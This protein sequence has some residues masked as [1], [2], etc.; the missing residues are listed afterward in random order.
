MT[1]DRVLSEGLNYPPHGVVTV[2]PSE[3]RAEPGDLV[4]DI[5]P[6]SRGWL[7]TQGLIAEV[8]DAA[9]EPDPQD[10]PP[11]AAE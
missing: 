5:P 9:P 8:L 7:Q 2:P 11:P 3:R 4:D 6:Q 1:V 10:E